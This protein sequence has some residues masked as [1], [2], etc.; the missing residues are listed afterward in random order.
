MCHVLKPDP[1]NPNF[2]N[3]SLKVLDI[4]YN[5]ITN[6]SLRYLAETL[7]TNRSLEYLGLAKVHA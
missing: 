4:S 1:S 5:P 6:L 7:E 3:K 2:A